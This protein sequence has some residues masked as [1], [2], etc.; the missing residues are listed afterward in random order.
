M[1]KSAQRRH[2]ATRILKNW[3]RNI[4]LS[5]CDEMLKG[6][7]WGKVFNQD[8]WDCGNPRCYL[9]SGK[10]LP[11]KE[12]LKARLEERQALDELLDLA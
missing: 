10:Y 11:N 4:K 1:T 2:D 6:L 12:R 5:Q 7:S 9:C 8:P 3:E